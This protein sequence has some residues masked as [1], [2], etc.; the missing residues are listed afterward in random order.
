MTVF[1]A[2]RRWVLC[3]LG[4]AF[5]SLGKHPVRLQCLSA[6]G[7]MRTR[8]SI[9]EAITAVMESS[10]P[11]GG[12]SY[13]D[14]EIEDGEIRRQFMESSVPFGGGSYADRGLC[15]GRRESARSLQCLSAVGPM[16]TQPRRRRGPQRGPRLQCLSAVGPMRTPPVSAE[17]LRRRTPGLQ[18]L[19]AVGPMR[20]WMH[21]NET[22]RSLAGVFSAFRRW[23]LCGLGCVSVTKG[24][25]KESS[26]PFGGGSYA[27]T[28]AQRR[29]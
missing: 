10:V 3:G 13:A 19:S 24:K 7:P 2:F 18:C 26:V 23:V 15:R 5:A 27:D 28:N 14:E 11:F 21:G 22:V 12:G 16:R 1:S 29:R 25:L 20:T 8:D 9:T 17:R 4:N 6:V